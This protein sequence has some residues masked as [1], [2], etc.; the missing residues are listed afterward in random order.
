MNEYIKA[1]AGELVRFVIDVI[2]LIVIF[3]K[4]L[5]TKAE[6]RTEGE[7]A[8]NGKTREIESE[9]Q[10]LKVSLSGR[11]IVSI[12]SFA[13]IIKRQ[14]YLSCSHTVFIIVLS[15]RD[16]TRLMREHWRKVVGA[17]CRESISG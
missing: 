15:G 7:E 9:T 1:Y 2:R 17:G 5:E 13:I 16:I 14:R 6:S 3:K 10:L 8:E 11:N 12:A 4:Q